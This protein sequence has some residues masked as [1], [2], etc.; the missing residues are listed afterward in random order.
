MP[1]LSERDLNGLLEIVG[2]IHHAEDR[3]SFRAAL[4][5]VLPR[6]IPAPIIS[7]NEVGWDGRPG[8]TL[9]VPEL[10]PD[11]HELWRRLAYQ[12]PLLERYFAT[13]DGRA[14][15]FSDVV[16]MPELRALELYRELYR[17]S[18]VEHQ[19][20]VILP[21]PP[22]LIVGVVLSGP[23]DFT[24]AQRLVLDLARP[25]IIQAFANATLLESLR[26]V[27]AALT[28]GLEDSSEAVVVVDADERV[29]HSTAAGRSAVRLLTGREPMTGDLLPPQLRAP[30]LLQT[31]RAVLRVAGGSPVVVR[32]VAAER[33]ASTV[34]VFD[35]GP[36]HAS[37]A[38]LE[39][40]GLTAR[41]AEVLQA[42]MRGESTEAISAELGITS[43]TVYKHAERIFS[44]LGV[45]ARVAAVSAAWAALD[46]APGGGS[47][48]SV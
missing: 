27:L 10:S 48:D 31:N 7:Y 22:D 16:A 43:R 35:R 14:Y 33:G 34:V 24:D 2:E 38:L 12:N 28:A 30:S 11:H 44:K 19:I 25:H 9:V 6:V 46:A 41:E 47:P 3:P 15:R 18:G 20:A 39:G 5:D 32:R 23:E 13:R 21:A 45:S 4:I 36:R 42:M 29:Q 26:D 8:V 17:P 37:R 40:L 1:S